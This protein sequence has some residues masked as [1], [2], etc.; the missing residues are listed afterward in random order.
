MACDR[1]SAALTAHALGAALEPPAA[2]HLAICARCQAWL[3]N[4]QSLARLLD[5]AIDAIGSVEPGADFRVRL[6]QRVAMPPAPARGWWRLAVGVVAL[7]A[8]VVMAAAIWW[9]PSQRPA[10]RASETAGRQDGGDAVVAMPAPDRVP[11]SVRVVPDPMPSVPHARATRAV[12]VAPMAPDAFEVL[13][14]AGQRESL[15][16]LV[17]SLSQQDPAV[18]SRLLGP[19]GE[20]PAPA[21]VSVAAVVVQ[22]LV[23]SDLSIVKP[24][25][26]D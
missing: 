17:A 10:A 3:A 11:E 24:I 21:E 13:V 23:V 9:Q 18:A 19:G 16:R 25:L 26:E 20:V 6:A 14:P 4:E 1:F 12:A 5:G 2:A 15:V 8:L 22:P 7:A